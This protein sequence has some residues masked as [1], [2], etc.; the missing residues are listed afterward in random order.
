MWHSFL[1]KRHFEISKCIYLCSEVEL[2]HTV[3]IMKMKNE[4]GLYDEECHLITF[5]LYT[6]ILHIFICYI[7]YF[8][9]LH[10]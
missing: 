8:Y 1:Q 7:L 6:Y 3:V 4:Y 2:Y 5:I 10:Y 9:M